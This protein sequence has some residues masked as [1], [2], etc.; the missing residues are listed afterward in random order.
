MGGMKNMLVAST[1]RIKNMMMYRMKISKC[2]LHIGVFGI[3]FLVLGANL[4]EVFAEVNSGNKK[5][6]ECVPVGIKGINLS[7]LALIIHEAHR[8]KR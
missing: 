6:S 5:E 3:V 2:T 1:R 4:N 7:R 8:H